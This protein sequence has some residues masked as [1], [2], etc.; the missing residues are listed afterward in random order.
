MRNVYL[1][2]PA[3]LVV[4]LSASG[5]DWQDCKSDGSY[6]FADAKES[7]RRQTHDGIS[8]GLDDK[9]ISRSGDLASVAILQTLSDEELTSQKTLKQVL[10]LLRTAFACPHRC[11]SAIG[12]RQPRVTLLLLEHL[13]SSTHGSVRSDIEETRKFI[14]RQAGSTE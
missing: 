13:H 7:V 4:A 5:Q 10:S 3:I 8:L 11:V 9:I 2:L 14:L 12:D 6:S 1:V